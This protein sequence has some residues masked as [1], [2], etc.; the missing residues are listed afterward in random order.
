M[1]LIL[2]TELKKLKKKTEE[3]SQPHG[4]Y[5]VKH[6][7]T[8]FRR[9]QCDICYEWKGKSLVATAQHK[10]QKHDVIIDTFAKY[11]CAVEGCGF[12]TVADYSLESHNKMVHSEEFAHLT[13]V[14]HEEV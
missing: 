4:W 12:M 3:L 9:Y 11:T 13:Q 7:F 10:L 8:F 2:A 5:L 6:G 1:E 14:A